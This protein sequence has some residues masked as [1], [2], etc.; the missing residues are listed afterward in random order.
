VFARSSDGRILRRAYDGSNWGD[1]ANLAALDGQI[2]DARSDLD[3]SANGTTIHLVAAGLNPIGGLLRAFG[4]NTIYNPFVRELASFSFA[5]SP[6]IA[7]VTD[8]HYF[9]GA[10]AIG[11][12]TPALYELGETSST[13]QLTPIATEAASIR[14]GPDIAFQTFGASLVTHFVGFDTAGNLAVYFHVINSGGAHWEDPV[15]LSPPLGTFTFS[16]T[17]C[18]ENGGFGVTSINLVAA[19]GGQLWHSQS[20]SITSAFS[21]WAPIASA[22]ASSPDCTVTGPQSIVHVVA[23]STAGTVLD[24]NGKGT[25]W[26]VTD[27]GSPR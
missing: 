14:S 2:I 15:K 16:P 20:S 10:L 13:R 27:L 18:T 3:C 11:G 6:S 24:V 19:A 1:W 22:P 7:V 8:T 23:A 9:L 26:V 5:P 12:T 17:V 4:S 21:S 25:T